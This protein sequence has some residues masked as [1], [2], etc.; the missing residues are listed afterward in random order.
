MKM[1]MK[2]IIAEN[3]KGIKVTCNRI[4]P[5]VGVPVI[6]N[7]MNNHMLRQCKQTVTLTKITKK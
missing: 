6:R 4:I 2:K 1:K 5:T 7:T 3:Q